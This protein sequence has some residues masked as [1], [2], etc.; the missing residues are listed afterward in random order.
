MHVQI[1]SIAFTAS[2]EANPN[3]AF[4]TCGAQ[5]H[6]CVWEVPN[7][8]ATAE[9]AITKLSPQTIYIPTTCPDFGTLTAI[10]APHLSSLAFCATSCGHLLAIDLTSRTVDKFVKVCGDGAA[11]FTVAACGSTIAVGCSRGVCRLFSTDTLAF[12]KALPLPPAVTAIN[13]HNRPFV[14][15]QRSSSAMQK[16]VAATVAVGLCNDGNR[17]VTLY[18]DRSLFVWDCK[19]LSASSTMSFSKFRSMLHHSA[20]V[21]CGTSIGR[22]G[23]YA[24]G[25]AYV[26]CASD[27]SVRVWSFGGVAQYTQNAGN[28]RPSTAIAAGA[29]SS[30][31]GVAAAALRPLS[32]PEQPAASP[33]ASIP[34]HLLSKD[35]VC[36]VFLPCS[37][38]GTASTIECATAAVVVDVPALP[39]QRCTAID[40]DAQQGLT[41]IAAS[42]A[43][44]H[45]AVADAS[46]GV[47]IVSTV[48]MDPVARIP[49]DTK[50]VIPCS[51]FPQL[52]SHA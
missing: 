27:A 34:K 29:V 14:T 2:S 11:C 46:G 47:H 3:E 13:V 45:I 44:E 24:V 28:A 18:G 39:G 23:G 7:V 1:W 8:D 43:I 25:D 50:A 15:P 38:E 33:S 17:V 19:Q 37:A 5:G 26:T 16:M 10:T 48:A 41:A 4:Y 21:H 52:D 9:T 31:S 40:T 35:M 51:L 36:A 42:S 12:I 32:A 6:L 30:G 20:G 22:V 49:R